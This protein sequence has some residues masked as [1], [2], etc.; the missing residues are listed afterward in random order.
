[1]VQATSYTYDPYGTDR[2]VTIDLYDFQI[3]DMIRKGIVGQTKTIMIGEKDHLEVILLKRRAQILVGHKGIFQK[4]VY[5]TREDY[6]IWFQGRE[7][8]FPN[9]H[10]DMVLMDHVIVSNY[11]LLKRLAVLKDRKYE[12]LG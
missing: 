9:D 7:I 5:E 1:M 8:Y 2:F 3:V 10:N 12:A 6:I 4:P 11:Y